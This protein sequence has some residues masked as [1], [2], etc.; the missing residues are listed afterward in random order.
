M[1]TL[2]SHSLS[3]LIHLLDATVGMSEK[4]ECEYFE[5]NSETVMS[6]MWDSYTF[7]QFLL[8]LSY[9]MN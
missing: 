5:G 8:G 7:P 4:T 2:I 3:F 6:V 1:N 9:K